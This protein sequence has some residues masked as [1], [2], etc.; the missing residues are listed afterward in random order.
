MDLFKKIED[1]SAEIA[2]IGMGYVGFPLAVEFASKGFSVTGVDI[3]ELKV[4]VIN[5]GGS[6]IPDIDPDDV[7]PLVKAGRPK[8]T[9]D[10]DVLS[11]NAMMRLAYSSL[12]AV[13]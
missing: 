11:A 2:I 1:R 5:H 6:H 7:S 4:K 8:A 9:A 10:F 12:S 13:R 3:N